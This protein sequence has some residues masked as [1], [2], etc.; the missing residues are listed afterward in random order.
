MF[1]YKVININASLKEACKQ[2]TRQDRK[3]ERDD[4]EE[5]QKE[6][7]D[8]F[9]LHLQSVEVSAPRDWSEQ[10]SHEHHEFLHQ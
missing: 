10:E 8:F 7:G 9:D 4:N 5:T 6:S 2:I 3:E 1:E